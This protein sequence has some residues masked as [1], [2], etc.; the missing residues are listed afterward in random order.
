V[1]EKKL[2]HNALS[3]SRTIMM[4]TFPVMCEAVLQGIGNALFL[5]R[6]SLRQ[7]GL[8]EIPVIELPETYETWLVST[9]D[10]VSLGLVS[11][12][13]AAALETAIRL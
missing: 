2:K 7:D 3:A 9:K 8:S 12:F 5:D 11:E 1:I 4:T 10:S 6:S 13:S